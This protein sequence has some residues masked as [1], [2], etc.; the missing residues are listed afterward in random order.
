M[1]IIELIKSGDKEAIKQVYKDNSNEVYDFAKSITGDHETALEATKQTFLA[2]FSDVQAG[3][4][5]ANIRSSLL[6]LAHDEACKI[7]IPSSVEEQPEEV[8]EQ[9]EEQYEEPVEE[10]PE[11]SPAYD[12]ISSPYEDQGS[13]IDALEEAVGNCE[14]D[15]ALGE[16]RVISLPK[17]VIEELVEDEED[18]TVDDFVED[19][20]YYDDEPQDDRRRGGYDDY[21]EYDDYDDGYDD[22]D[23]YDEYDDDY[24]EGSRSSGVFA[25]CLIICIIFILILLWFA[26]GLLE[27][28]GIIPDIN[29]GYE[30]FNAHIRDIF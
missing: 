25:V 21:D 18:R 24:E 27:H 17:E 23:E 1:D 20:D 19:D 2:F 13:G 11:E 14:T 3:E 7:V 4:R 28:K 16:T 12:R 9:Y 22:Y 30:W 15:G 29:L 5:P 10:Q 6:K 26:V 8:V